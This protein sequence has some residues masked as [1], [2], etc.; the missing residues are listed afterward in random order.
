MVVSF[1]DI[2]PRYS[3]AAAASALEGGKVYLWIV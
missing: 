1:L 3:S 2:E